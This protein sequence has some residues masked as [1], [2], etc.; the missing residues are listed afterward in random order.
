MSIEALRTEIKRAAEEE[1]KRILLDAEQK[2]K[3]IINDAEQKAKN[4]MERRMQE[5]IRKLEEKEK[6]ELAIARIDGRKKVLDMRSKYLEEVFKEV[7]NR[8]SKVPIENRELYKK[9]LSD[10]IIEGIKNLGDSKFLIRINQRDSEI[11]NDVI[12]MVKKKLHNKKI[13]IRVSPEPLNDAGGV[14][15]YTEDM[16]LYYTNTFESRLMKFKSENRNK[17]LEILL[18]SIQ[19][20]KP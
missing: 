4:I 6:V 10:F 9:V 8:L 16:K 3:N 20:V 7:E 17:V 18:K 1:S 15:I 2:A 12:E 5:T 13:E 14:I 19:E 11:I